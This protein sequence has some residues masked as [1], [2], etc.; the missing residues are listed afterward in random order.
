MWAAVLQGE[1]RQLCELGAAQLDA[2]SHDS[3]CKMITAAVWERRK[4]GAPCAEGREIGRDRI[5]KRVA[6]ARGSS[7]T[8]GSDDQMQQNAKQ[9]SQPAS[10]VFVSI[11]INDGRHPSPRPKIIA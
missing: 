10:I 1:S 9:I 7:H 3:T 6:S 4:S 11:V 2:A 5:N 8:R